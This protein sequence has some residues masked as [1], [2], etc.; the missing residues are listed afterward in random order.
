[1]DKNDDFWDTIGPSWKWIKSIDQHK[2]NNN[3]FMADGNVRVT[4]QYY[5]AGISDFSRKEKRI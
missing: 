5:D 4:C 2:I 3:R 1:M